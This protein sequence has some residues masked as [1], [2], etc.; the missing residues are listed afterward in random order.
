M[1]RNLHRLPDRRRLVSVFD[2]GDEPVAF[3]RNSLDISR[4]FRVVAESGPNL[5]DAEVDGMLEIDKC[6]V[7][8]KV[9]ADVFASDEL[10]VPRNQKSEQPKRLMLQPNDLTGLGP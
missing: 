9:F 6:L 10:A 1:R 2:E 5:A 7:I 4:R 8:P 3:A